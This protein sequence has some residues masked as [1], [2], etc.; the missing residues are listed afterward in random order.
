MPAL[1]IYLTV[2]MRIIS[3]KQPGCLQMYACTCVCT[4]LYK[5]TH[6]RTRKRTHT[7]TH[8]HTHTCT[9]FIGEERQKQGH[10]P[11][12]AQPGDVGANR[13][14]SRLFL[15]SRTFHT[16][17][18]SFKHSEH[19]SNSSIVFTLILSANTP[20]IL[21]N[22]CA[23]A[24]IVRCKDPIFFYSHSG[25][26]PDKLEQLLPSQTLT[27]ASLVPMTSMR[28]FSFFFFSCIYMF[29]FFTWAGMCFSDVS[30]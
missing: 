28:Y 26:C 18:A 17:L 21:L 24:S 4:H 2:L 13:H 9:H 14:P 25:T 12:G 23:R 29:Y 8:T 22:G 3:P 1:S 16:K 19:N 11:K 20:N 27:S 6:T 5:H 30:Q 10:T 15:C 7:H